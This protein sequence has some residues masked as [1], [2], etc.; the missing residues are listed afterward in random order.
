MKRDQHDRSTQAR[1]D[2]QAVQQHTADTWLLC[3]VRRCAAAY[4]ELS[5]YECKKAMELLDTLPANVQAGSWSLC[6]F[7]RA[8]YEMADYEVVSIARYLSP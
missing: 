4:F 5:R 8:F 7:G 1:A 3:L 2:I 6:M